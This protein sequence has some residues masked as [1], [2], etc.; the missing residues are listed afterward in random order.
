MRDETSEAFLS[1]NDRLNAI[2]PSDEQ[3]EADE[4]AVSLC[5]R[6]GVAL[7]LAVE[8]YHYLA[9]DWP[10]LTKM[11]LQSFEDVLT[12]SAP[13]EF[14]DSSEIDEI[15]TRRWQA[16][17]AL[18]VFDNPDIPF[19]IGSDGSVTLRDDDEMF[20]KLKHSRKF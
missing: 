2:K 13:L 5:A 7:A 1:V 15:H 10:A 17:R 20:V 19:A 8:Q 14:A 6:P 9:R 4:R 3:L 12:W 11:D 16:L 18:Y